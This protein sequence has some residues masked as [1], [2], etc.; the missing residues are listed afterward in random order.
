M[1]AKGSVGFAIFLLAAN[2]LLC[3][4]IIR[5]NKWCFL[6]MTVFSFNPALWIINGIY[7]KNRWNHPRCKRGEM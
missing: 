7:L 5:Y 6:V 4:G 2:L 1:I 3:L